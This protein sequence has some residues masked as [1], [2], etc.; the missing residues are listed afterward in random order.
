MNFR[1]FMEKNKL[2]NPTMKEPELQRV[3]NYPISRKDS[4]LYSDK[5]FVK[6]ENGTLGGSHWTCFHV[7]NNK[8]Y[9]FDSF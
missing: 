2:K 5:G 8:S 6:F 9:Y 4:K 7:K 3:Y 1:E